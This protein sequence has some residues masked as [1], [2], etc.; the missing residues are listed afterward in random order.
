MSWFLQIFKAQ[1]IFEIKLVEV[2][3]YN[4]TNQDPLIPKM[5]S[6]RNFPYLKKLSG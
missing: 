5:T 2:G 1:T 6:N 3:D 4:S